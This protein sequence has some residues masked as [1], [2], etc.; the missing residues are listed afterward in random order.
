MDVYID[1][2]NLY[3]MGSIQMLISFHFFAKFL[4]K[5]T[6]LIHY[7][8]FIS[9]GLVFTGLPSESFN[10]LL[11]YILLLAADGIIILKGDICL[12]VLYSM[13]T[14]VIMQLCYGFFN[15]VL[16]VFYTDMFSFN[17]EIS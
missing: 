10:G 12:S 8:L 5:Q 13:V 7:I 6:K 17:N 11:L 3:V 2:F 9:I 15:S 14:V 1:V 4:K 16:S